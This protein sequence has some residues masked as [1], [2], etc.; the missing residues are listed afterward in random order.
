MTIGKNVLK[1]STQELQNFVSTRRLARAQ[2]VYKSLKRKS[3]DQTVGKIAK[4]LGIQSEE[5]MELLEVEFES[6]GKL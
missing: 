2:T 1:M 5:L 4:D 6:G 3:K